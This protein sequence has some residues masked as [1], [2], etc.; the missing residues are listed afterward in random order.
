M[1]L[2]W[3]V[4]VWNRT[5]SNAEPLL[6]RGARWTDHPLRECTWVV[7]CLYTSAIVEDVLGQWTE[8]PWTCRYII[9]TTTGESDATRRLETAWGGRGIGYLEAPISGSSEQTRRGEAMVMVGATPERFEA[10]GMLLKDLGGKVVAVGPVGNAS[11]LKLITNLVL[12]LNRAVLAEGLAFGEALGVPAGAALDVLRGS[13]AYSKAMDVK[14]RKM[15][16]REYGVQA[17]LSQHLKDVRM[18][19]AE[20]GEAGLA[21][22]LTETHR[23]VLEEAERMGLGGLDNSAVYEVWGSKKTASPR[24]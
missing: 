21:L 14:G 5:R 17:R 22:P 6:T 16:E 18:M 15:V 19:L 2:G 3:E 24:E 12:G 1:A 11:K 9:D 23:D 13:N 4:R 7:V 10:C 8:G 20:A